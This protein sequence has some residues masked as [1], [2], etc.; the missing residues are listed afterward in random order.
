MSLF[1]IS[2]MFLKH[3]HVNG[4]TPVELRMESSFPQLD[5]ACGRLANEI[6]E[7]CGLIYLMNSFKSLPLAWLGEISPKFSW[8]CSSFYL[9]FCNKGHGVER[10]KYK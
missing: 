2:E 1:S 7:D 6:R 9:F 3:K 8:L 5:M 10:M 4:P